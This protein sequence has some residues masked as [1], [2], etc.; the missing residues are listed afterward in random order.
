MKTRRGKI[1][2]QGNVLARLRASDQGPDPRFRAVLRERLVAAAGDRSEDCRN[3]GRG[4]G[5]GEGVD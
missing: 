1:V 5:H 3:H 2:E 4:D